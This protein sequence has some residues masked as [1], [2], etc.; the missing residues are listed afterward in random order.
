MTLFNYKA[1]GADGVPLDGTMEAG[2]E[3]L[4]IESLNKQGLIP[5]KVFGASGGAV[6]DTPAKKS[7]SFSLFG[8]KKVSQPDIMA[9]TQQLSSM[10]KAG[11]PLDRALGIQLEILENP[12]LEKMIAGVQ[13]KVRGGVHFADALE[14]SKQFS[15]F[16]INMVKAGEASGSIDD[17][18]EKLVEYMQRAK[19]LRG[20]VISALIYPAI[21]AFVA[22]LSVIALLLFVVPQFSEMFADMGAELPTLTKLVV[23]AGAFLENY[24]WAVLVGFLVLLVFVQYLFTNEKARLW[25]DHSMLKWPLVG[26][27]VGKVEMARFSRGLST[28]LSN[29]VPLL[30]SLQIVKNIMGNRI[31]A[32]SVGEAADSLKQG[33]SLTKTLLSKKVFPAYALHMLRV[34]E[35]TGRMEELLTDVADIYDDEVK[36]SVRQMLALMEPLL[37][38]IMAMAILVILFAVLIPM[39][40]MGD[41]VQ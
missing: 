18:L 32:K 22:I 21:L 38:L 20:I 11:L 13:E 16:Y 33:E 4:V 35:E 2:S 15:R 10:L 34:G 25:L 5:L 17:A 9:F 41:L 26:D 19:E 14:D 36:T 24:W 29:G 40:S 31:M 1:I 39:I 27:L 8:S 3:A 30:G 37:I 6:A 28:L 23:A 12:P 7:K